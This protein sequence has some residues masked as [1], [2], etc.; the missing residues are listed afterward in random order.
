M[1]GKFFRLASIAAILIIIAVA[2]PE[3][4][5]PLGPRGDAGNFIRKFMAEEIVFHGGGKH[6]CHGRIV[7]NSV[8]AVER[9]L[10]P[11]VRRRS[12]F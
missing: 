7:M 11:D 9:N 2:R 1:D 10:S 3:G 12:F 6:R 4:F 8:G 5:I